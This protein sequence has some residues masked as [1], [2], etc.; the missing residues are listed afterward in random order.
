ML[1]VVLAMK[2]LVTVRLRVLLLGVH[3][4]VVCSEYKLRLP[5]LYCIGIVITIYW[6]LRGR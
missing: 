2:M 6:V 3:V 1:M 5:M 4:K